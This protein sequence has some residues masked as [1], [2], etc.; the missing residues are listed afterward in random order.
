MS[1]A[2][3][4]SSSADGQ[5]G[6][7]FSKLNDYYVACQN[8]NITEIKRML[9]RKQVDP[10]NDVCTRTGMT[11]LHWAAMNNK[12][13]TCGYLLLQGVDINAKTLSTYKLPEMTAIQIAAR[14]GYVYT[15]HYLMEHGAD[16]LALTTTGENLLHLAVRSSNPMNLIYILFWMNEPCDVSVDAADNYGRSALHWAILQEDIT[17]VKVLLNYGA[18]ITLEDNEGNSALQYAAMKSNKEINTI[19][20]RHL[21]NNSNL[22]ETDRLSVGLSEAAIAFMSSKYSMKNVVY[23][24]RITFMLPT[25]ILLT[26]IS[27]ARYN[28]LLALML[29]FVISKISDILLCRFLLPLFS[30]DRTNSKAFT[31]SPI[32]SGLTFALLNTVSYIWIV[33]I[34]KFIV[35]SSWVPAIIFQLSLIVTYILFVK[36]IRSDPGIIPREHNPEK[37]TANISSLIKEGRFN[38]YYFCLETWLRKPLRSRFSEVSQCQVARYDHYCS[39]L[40]NDI[41]LLNHKMFLFFLVSM[42]TSLIIFLYLSIRYLQELE[43][44]LAVV[45]LFALNFKWSVDPSTSTNCIVVILL[46][47]VTQQTIL[48]GNILLQQCYAISKGMT[49][50]EIKQL[51]ELERSSTVL[52][53]KPFVQDDYYNVS[54]H[55]I[56][57]LNEKSIPGDGDIK[58]NENTKLITPCYSKLVSRITSRRLLESRQRKEDER[59][60]LSKFFGF[61]IWKVL[62]QCDEEITIYGDCELPNGLLEPTT[63]GV[64][65]NIKDFWLS[66]DQS[67]YIISRLLCSN[68]GP[69]AMLNGCVVD[70]YQLRN[71]PMKKCKSIDIERTASGSKLV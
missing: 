39:W 59:D 55:E 70:Y 40:N 18:D 34:G 36:L 14:Y 22:E 30:H 54:T 62:K 46:L 17:S 50:Y 60:G 38:D 41:G 45:S 58:T 29:V 26:F 67:R 37:I 44:F 21:M 16:P 31:R 10:L 64:F 48:V 1:A 43:S 47:L 53:S 23:A 42:E 35:H 6:S 65:R 57:V 3:I 11:G 2:K 27:C 33:N 12:L 49:C 20:T 69:E 68:K 71:F 24:K 66:A 52:Y 63:F 25:V 56:S 5:Y 15:V 61:D 4:G 8:G 32:I 19:I 13:E 51:Y 9:Y 7:Q 28:L